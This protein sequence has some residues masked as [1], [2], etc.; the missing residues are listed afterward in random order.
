MTSQQVLADRA[1]SVTITGHIAAHQ[2]RDL[3][4]VVQVP[5]DGAVVTHIDAARSE[6][7]RRGY[8]DAPLAGGVALPL[9][10]RPGD[11]LVLEGGAAMRSDYWPGPGR[12][13]NAEAMA[14][15]FVDY[16]IGPG[17]LRPPALGDSWLSRFFRAV[18][19]P[20]SSVD[21]AQ[22]P[23]VI[24]VQELGVDW[25]AWGAAE[26][27]IPYLTALL[28]R[29][30][31]EHRSGWATDGDTPD[32]AHP[33]YGSYYASIVS[34]ALVQLCSTAPVESKRELALA[35]VQRG[36][37]L[38]GA[39][40]DGRVGYPLGGHCAGRKALIV[41]TGHLL[42][43]NPI[44]D[45]SAILGP[46]F[47]EDGCYRPGGWWFGGG[48]SARW[49]FRVEAPFDGRL[50]AQPPSTWGAVNAPGHD[51][52]A[53]MIAGYMPQVVGV[54][55]GTALAMRLMGR[56]REWSA[57]GDAMVAQWMAGPP[58]AADD[59]LR[60]AG[61]NLAWG[62]DYALYRGSGFCSAAWREYADSHR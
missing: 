50:L 24:D 41:A 51:S 1:L 10:V 54:Q 56:T 11:A 58:Q 55:V 49:Q 61:I 45:P 59:E 16:P 29:Y 40:A 21:L 7:N 12:S 44:A 47:Q 25:S 20:E 3:S 60:A 17:M 31:G 62:T 23:S 5:A 36:L 13:R 43:V 9:T 22:L 33:G 52:Q 15:V 14:V 6:L 35:I 42:G 26:P 37:D 27:T 8:A 19:V 28:R 32:A 38:V 4:W 39:W 18:S 53:W 30:G 57:S 34:Q 48:W 2:A 46:V